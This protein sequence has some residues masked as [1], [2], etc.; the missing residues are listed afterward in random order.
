MIMNR[1]AYGWGRT[2]CTPAVGEIFLDFI[3]AQIYEC[4]LGDDE[5]CEFYRNMCKLWNV[6]LDCTLYLET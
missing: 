4:Y 2:D 3:L 1:A 6:M 5:V